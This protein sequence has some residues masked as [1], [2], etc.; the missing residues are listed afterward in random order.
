MVSKITR[1][2]KV[3]VKVHYVGKR[4]HLNN[5]VNFFNYEICIENQ[6]TDEVQLL[7]R[8]WLIKDALNYEEIVQGEGVIGKTPIIKQKE[9]F[10]YTSG[11]L[12]QGEAGSM[13]GYFTFVNF[14]TSQLFHVKIPLFK[15][16][17]PSIFN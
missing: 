6:T 3:I 13:Q 1:G 14:T 10:Q 17:I 4:M 2:I 11:C 7:Q 15:L 8:Y 16:N 9:T 5:P 12:I